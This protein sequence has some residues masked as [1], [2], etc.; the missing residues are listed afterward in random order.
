M[1][2]IKI[3]RDISIFVV[4]QVMAGDIVDFDP[5]ASC[6]LLTNG[7]AETTQWELSLGRRDKNTKSRA[8]ALG[9][10]E[11][12]QVTFANHRVRWVILD[13]DAD[14]VFVRRLRRLQNPELHSRFV[15]E[16]R[17]GVRREDTSDSERTRGISIRNL[18]NSASACRSRNSRRTAIW[19]LEGMLCEKISVLESNL[20]SIFLEWHTN[21]RIHL[22]C[23]MESL[24]CPN[25]T[26][27][28]E[29]V[30]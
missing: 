17:N 11:R 30:K 8:V 28:T 22:T 29:I 4:G 15:S 16:P 24:I 6:H 5:K 12:K 13:T 7:R 14:D 3:E 19:D 27:L 20:D 21:V 25:S 18:V 1:L 23:G 2:R 9:S 10:A 26:S